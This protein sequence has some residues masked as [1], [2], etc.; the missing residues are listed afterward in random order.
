LVCLQ[1][2]PFFTAKVFISFA[3][4]VTFV[5]IIVYA[6]C[7]FSCSLSYLKLSLISHEAFYTNQFMCKVVTFSFANFHKV[8]IDYVGEVW[9]NWLSLLIVEIGHCFD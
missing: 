2:A 4:R 9:A 5:F 1:T 3:F 8:V 6:E 7:S